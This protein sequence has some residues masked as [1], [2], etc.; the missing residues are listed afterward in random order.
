LLVFALLAPVA[1][2]QDGDK[3]ADPLPRKE[4][5]RRLR[6]ILVESIRTGAPLYNSGDQAGC[7]RIYQG[8]L[9]A[10]D[11]LLD[12]RPEL[13]AAVRKG[14]ERAAKLRTISDKAFALRG[15]ID[16]AIETLGRDTTAKTPGGRS[17][18]DRLGGEKAVRAVVH[19]FVVRAAKDP[20]VNFDRG[21]KFKLE[22]AAVAQLE[23]HLVELV[24]AVGGGPLAYTG[25][26]M[27]S[28]HA[29]M[30]ITDSEF[31]ALTGHLIAVL[32]KYKVP[33]KEIDELVGAVASTRKD[34][35]EGDKGAK[36]GKS[37]Y[38][39]LGGEKAITAVVDRFV[40][41]AAENPKVNIT[42]KGT[43]AEWQP[44]PE[45]VAHLKKML[46]QLVGMVTG[47]PQKYEGK[48]MKAVHEGMMI[49][50]AEFNALAGELKATLDEFKV[51]QREQE[52]LLTI[53]ASTRADIVERKKE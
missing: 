43:K 40:V 50:D 51:P 21:G 20:K 22:P 8:S 19:D 2:A 48:S 37:L 15:V 35:V 16:V 53:I 11:P 33:Q 44:T 46:V 26:D 6:Q 34:I 27:K 18:W 45:N 47:G 1:V 49:T 14:L 29:G 7:Y 4:L 52:E 25:R 9:M 42:R 30:K 5:D 17:L 28:A 3:Q 41:R 10:V 31:D 12:H 39:R 23:Q 13:Q 38:E 32:K 36:T 24:S